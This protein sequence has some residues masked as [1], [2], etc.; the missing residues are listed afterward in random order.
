[1]KSILDNR[2]EL[3]RQVANVAEVAGYLWQKG[4]AERNGGNITINVTEFVDKMVKMEGAESG[5][6]F[7]TGMAAIYSTFATLLNAG[8]H[9]VSCQ[10]VFGSTHTLFTKYFP[11]W[12]IETTYFKAED[13]ENVEQYIKPNTKILYLETPTNPAIE[14]L[15]LEFFGQIAD[16]GERYSKSTE[17][18]NMNGNRGSKHFIYINRTFFGLYNLMHDLKAKNVKIN[19]FIKY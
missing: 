10:S 1:M 2:P 3:A 9:I 11:K 7:A 18:R 6:A 5:Y 14:V 15:D 8:D 19:N 16:L 13:A 4:W 17:L 12:N